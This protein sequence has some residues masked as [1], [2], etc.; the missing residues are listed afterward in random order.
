MRALNLIKLTPLYVFISFFQVSCAAG[1]II[2]GASKE[3][4]A[5]CEEFAEK[6]GMAF[7]STCPELFVQ[8]FG[9]D[10]LVTFF[11]PNELVVFVLSILLPSVVDD[12]LDV[13]STSAQLGK[14]AGKDAICHKTTYVT[15]LGLEKSQSE[16][17]RI[18]DEA[19]ACI[20]K[21]GDRAVPLLRIADYIVSRK[22]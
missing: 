18:I 7:Q 14:T 17:R 2:A 12:I 15:L 1:A 4:I 10:N 3:D 6:I 20:E 11:I 5:A 21:F 22:N 13:T 8:M 16:A 9:T 19:K